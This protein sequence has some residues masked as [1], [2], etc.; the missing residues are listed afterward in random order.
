MKIFCLSFLMGFI[1]ILSGSGSP[2]SNRVIENNSI[3]L[4]LSED[5]NGFEQIKDKKTG[6]NYASGLDSYLY[7]LKFGN[8]Y[9]DSMKITS[10]MA[11]KHESIRVKDGLELHYWHE[12]EI[13][14]TVVCKI[15]LDESSS[16]IKWTIT[17]TN[18]SKKI[19]R[20][21]E[22]PRI[23]CKTKLGSEALNDAVVFPV[24][25]G[26]LLTGMNKEGA[27]I[28]SSYP[29]GMSAQLLYYFD[30]QGGFYYAAYDG[31]GYKKTFSVSNSNNSLILSHEY[32]LP[33]EY[34]KEVELPYSVVTGVGGGKWEDGAGIYR[35][36]AKKQ[37]WCA[38]TL[39]KRDM[40][41]WL[42]YPNLFI[43][44]GY[45]SPDFKSVEKANSVIKKF[46]D[47]YNVPIIATGWSWEKNGIWIGP[48]YFPPVNGDQYYSDLAAK[49]KERGDHLH[50]YNSGFRW[51]VKKPLTERKDETKFTSLDGM[52]LFLKNGKS[53]AVVDAKGEL[54]FEKRPW[55][56]NYFL[57]PGSETARAILDSCNNHLFKWGV[58]G[59]DI[60]QN[61]GGNV[62]ECYSNEH[63]HPRGAGIWQY[64]A[65]NDFLV[66][67]RKNAKLISN[68]NFTGL[69]E[70]CE[71]FIPQVDVID[72]RNYTLTDWPVY[73]P[74]AISLPLYNFLYH[75]YQIIYSGWMPWRAPFG[76]A[77]NGIGRA[78]IFGF[79]PGIG[80]SGK[81]DLVKGEISDESKMVKG[82]VELMK[83]FPEFLLSG[84]M[85][86][87]LQ[88][89]GSDSLD[90][91]NKNGDSYPLKWKTVQGTVWQ[92]ESGKGM[93]CTLANLSDKSQE[94]KIKFLQ[95]AGQSFDN[96]GFVLDKQVMQKITSEKNGWMT[97]KL[98]PWQLSVIKLPSQ[99]PG[100]DAKISGQL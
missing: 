52:D 21:I 82:Y 84:K 73:G 78:F 14:L 70:P 74:G 86:G 75:Q 100:R 59:I 90:I 46:H 53:S 22:Y 25:E 58:S 41:P 56:H 47:F 88:V 95:N 98:A 60:D 26:A 6:R 17:V 76:I 64:K 8:N 38:N 24:H 9:L 85:I 62:D 93:A 79:Y 57:C 55:A 40:A 20:S 18:G 54:L 67:M 23:S 83:K 31:E 32:L 11:S 16:L 89:I 5:L 37:K 63:G 42:K 2:K 44:V 15:S 50:L 13:S 72:G 36:W 65:M 61:L 19:L 1:G 97:L 51:G 34:L 3:Y 48:D 92:A 43:L 80:T 39:S 7:R 96:V 94:I 77:K 4:E 91:V 87:D 28:K 35:D 68:D 30:P 12:G 81:F 69:E 45:N 99:L 29:G 27:T 66:N 33:V 49:V 71:I 10:A